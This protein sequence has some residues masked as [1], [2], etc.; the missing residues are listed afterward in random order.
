MIGASC[1][2][3]G[4]PTITPA[5]PPFQAAASPSCAD[6]VWSSLPDLRMPRAHM[7]EKGPL[8]SPETLFWIVLLDTEDR[9]AVWIVCLACYG[10][11]LGSLL[12]QHGISQRTFLHTLAQ[13]DFRHQDLQV[14]PSEPDQWWSS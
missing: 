13:E 6:V 9:V 14:P 8:L 5:R 7:H 12:P 11:F 10:L 4:S 1:E 2:A 3:E